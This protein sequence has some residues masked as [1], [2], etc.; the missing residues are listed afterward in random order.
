MK[1]ILA[2]VK[3]T[4]SLMESTINGYSIEIIDEHGR[5]TC[6]FLHSDGL[7]KFSSQFGYLKPN[8]RVKIK[9]YRDLDMYGREVFH[10]EQISPVNKEA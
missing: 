9:G 1:P 2:S 5:N 7:S 8:R 4:L 3:G 6:C 10:I